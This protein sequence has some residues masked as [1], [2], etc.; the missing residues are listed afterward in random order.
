MRDR[1][2]EIRS[3]GAELAIVGNGAANFAKAFRD[4]YANGFAWFKSQREAN[5]DHGVE[6]VGEELRDMMPWLKPVKA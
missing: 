4:D 3:L 2:D 1:Q 5:A 6:K